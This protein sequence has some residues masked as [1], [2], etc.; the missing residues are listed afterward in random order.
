[1]FV[2]DG[3]RVSR[4]VAPESQRGAPCGSVDFFDFPLDAP[5]GRAANARWSFGRYSERYSGIHAGEDWVYDV[6]DSLGK[7]VYSIGHGTVLY[8]Q[9]LGWGV[10]QGTLIVRHVFTDGHSILSTAICSRTALPASGTCV[11]RGQQ[12]GLIGKPRGRPH[13]L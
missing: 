3:L 9:P 1:L 10:D 13:P 7:P 4:S 12:V 2:F 5:E 6:R 11:T 8:A